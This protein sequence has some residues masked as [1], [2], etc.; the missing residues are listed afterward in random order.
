VSADRQRRGE[1]A[2]YRK[3]SGGTVRW[4]DYCRAPGATAHKGSHVRFVGELMLARNAAVYTIALTLESP[5]ARFEPH[6]VI[7]LGLR[8]AGP[9]IAVHLSW[10]HLDALAALMLDARERFT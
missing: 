8:T 9:P 6:P 1:T 10:E 4:C 7:W 5:S 2:L 3:H